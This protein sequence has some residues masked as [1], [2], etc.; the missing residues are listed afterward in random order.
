MFYDS[1]HGCWYAGDIK[2]AQ[3]LTA[4]ALFS[5]EYFN[6]NIRRIEKDLASDTLLQI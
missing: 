1:Y 5:P 2:K 6:S 4:V 3:T